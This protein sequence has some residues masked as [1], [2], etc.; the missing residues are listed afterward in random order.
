MSHLLLYAEIIFDKNVSLED[1][2]ITFD[3]SD[4][5]YFIEVD[6][7]YPYKKRNNFP[8][9]PESKIIGSDTFTTYK[10]KIKPK[11]YKKNVKK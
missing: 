10:K 4:I 8:S 2:L 7:S 9:A 1:S 5:C 6:L 11:N 3:D